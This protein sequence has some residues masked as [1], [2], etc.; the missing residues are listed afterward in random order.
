M[1]IDDLRGRCCSWSRKHF[2]IE[3]EIKINIK[4][5]IKL[6]T[7]PNVNVKKHFDRPK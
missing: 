7:I 3:K 4:R 2:L 1:H 5:L 6:C